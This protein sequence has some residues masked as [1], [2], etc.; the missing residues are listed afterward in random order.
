[1]QVRECECGAEIMMLTHVRTGNRGP[2]TVKTFPDGNIA[3]VGEDQYRIISA[4]ESY[5]GDRHKSHFVDCPRRKK[6]GG[7]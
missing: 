6:F 1:M 4:G 3:R 5:E 7:R 2:I